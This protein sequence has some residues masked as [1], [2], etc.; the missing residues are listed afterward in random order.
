[1]FE[2]S[3]G[4]RFNWASPSSPSKKGHFKCYLGTGPLSV[5]VGLLSEEIPFMKQQ[6]WVL[7]QPFYLQSMSDANQF[8]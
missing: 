5:Q 7:S 4:S 8:N 6:L 2:L 1:M 3:T